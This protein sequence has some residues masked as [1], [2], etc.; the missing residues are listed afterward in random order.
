MKILLTTLHAKYSHASLAL[1]CLAAYSRDMP[2]IET[3]IREWSVNDP[4][5]Q[6]LRQIMSERA[7]LVGFSCY[8][9]NIDRTLQ[10]I[11]D[12]RKIAPETVIVLGGPEVSFG[13]FELMSENPAIDFV[14]KGEGEIPVRR[15]LEALLKHGAPLSGH[16]S[17]DP[18]V[19]AEIPCLFFRDCE[20]ITSGPAAPAVLPLDDIPSPFPSG[21]V[22]LRRSLTYYET[23][24]GCPFSCAF[25]LSSVEG[26]VRSFSPRRIESDLEWLMRRKV[27][28]IK[29]VDRTFNYDA[30]RANRIWEFIL[31][32]NRG[33][34]FHFE[35]AADLLTEENLRLLRRVPPDTFR[36]EIGVQSTSQDT[37]ERVN[38]TADLSGIFARVR[39]L[40]EETAIELHLDLVAG[41]PGEDY[42]GL[43]NSLQQV[44]ELGPDVIQIEPLKVLKGSPMREIAHR[45]G[46]RFSDTPPYTILHT[47]WLSFEDIGRI[48]IIGRL[49]DLF[50]N[51]GGFGTALRFMLQRST[52]AALFDR[53]ARRAGEESLAGHATRR[54]YELFARLAGPLLNKAELHLLHDALFFD[55]CRRE[56]PLMGKLPGFM[57]ARQ[58]WCAWPSRREIPD[59][60]NLPENC[61]VKVFRY[62]FERD[63]RTDEWQEGPATI[64]FVYASGA[65]QGLRVLVA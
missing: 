31:E 56:M 18:G 3:V 41:L 63:Y 44:F 48:A 57:A 54:L 9:W 14:V 30:R 64:T 2:G 12:L 27:S 25:C 26:R 49:L 43:L 8:I 15:L 23:S 42:A 24:R 61:R 38:R 34:H 10:L 22:D 7:G 55:Y 65:G 32:H 45:E 39:R 17:A 47:P 40:R 4:H 20:G 46:Y 51:Q 5:D 33:S 1:P 52:P 28:Q 29:L 36:F 59:G 37:L 13:I 21:L 50:H 19:L 6:L 62:T 53:M 58:Q 35:I 16:F 60:L 11:S